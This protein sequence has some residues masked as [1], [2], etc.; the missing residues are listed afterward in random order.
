MTSTQN[1][2]SANGQNGQ[3]TRSKDSLQNGVNGQSTRSKD[4]LQNGVNGDGLKASFGK[5]PFVDLRTYHEPG[6]DAGGSRLR[7]LVWWLIQGVLFPLSP[8]FA[9]GPRRWLLRQFGAKVG[10][11]VR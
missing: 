6:Y 8:H 5:P 3:S 4:S 9:H 10:A 1:N 2:V 7:M 11:G